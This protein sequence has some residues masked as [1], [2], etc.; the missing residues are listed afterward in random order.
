[1]H[2]LIPSL[3]KVREM[4]RDALECDL[5]FVGFIV[6]SCPLKV[7][8]RPVIREIQNASHH[9]SVCQKLEAQVGRRVSDTGTLG[10]FQEMQALALLDGD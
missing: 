6:V 8:S 1:M 3:P 7:D 10:A 9:V 4:K 2:N 5:R